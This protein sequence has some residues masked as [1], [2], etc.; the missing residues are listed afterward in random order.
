MVGNLFRVTY[1]SIT[2]EPGMEAVFQGWDGG[3]GWDSLFPCPPCLS[4]LPSCSPS[5]SMDPPEEE[6]QVSFASDL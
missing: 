5:L 3:P 6:V 1:C 2:G 4:C